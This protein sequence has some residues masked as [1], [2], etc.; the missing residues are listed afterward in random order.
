MVGVRPDTKLAADVGAKLGVKGAIVVEE[1]MRTNLP[2]IYA[3]GDRVHAHH[4]PLGLWWRCALSPTNKV[5]SPVRTPSAVAHASSWHPRRQG[6]RPRRGP[7][8]AART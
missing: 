3:A 6:L 2:D 8:R 4:R 5:A 1:A 7:H